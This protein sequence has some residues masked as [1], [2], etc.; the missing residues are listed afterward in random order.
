M[1]A[2]LGRPL[3]QIPQSSRDDGGKE[4]GLPFWMDLEAHGV[5]RPHFPKLAA[6]QEVDVL[7]VGAGIVGLKMAHYASKLGLSVLVAEGSKIGHQAASARNQGCLQF[8]VGDYVAAKAEIGDDAIRL[9][10][11][12]MANRARVKSQLT[13]YA[14]DCDWLDNGE[15]YFVGKVSPRLP[16]VCHIPPAF[17]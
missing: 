11:L 5:S 14:I 8:V 12:G 17:H 9:E 1:A 13:E 2:Q 15:A 10:R 16:C 3:V 7:V 6:D 4:W